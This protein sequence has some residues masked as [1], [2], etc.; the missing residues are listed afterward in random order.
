[1]EEG[2]IATQ[3][4]IFEWKGKRQK[5]QVSKWPPT[6]PN[7]KLNSG[8]SSASTPTRDSAPTCPDCGRRHRGTCYRVTG[9]C[10]KIVLKGID[11]MGIEPLLVGSTLI[12]STKLVAKTT[13]NKDTARQGTVFALVPGDVQNAVA[14]VSSTFTIHGHS[15]HVLFHS[16]STH[17]FVSKIFVQ[18]LNRPVELLP[19]VLCVSSP[20]GDFMACT[21]IYFACEFLIRDTRVYANLL[22]LDMTHFDIILGMDW[23]SEYQTTIDYVTKQISFHPPGQ[24]EFTFKGHGVI[25]PPYLISAMKGC[26]LLQKG[27]QGY[28][29][30]VLEGQ[31]MNGGIDMISIVREFPDVFPEELPGELV[32][33]KIEFTIEV[34]PGTQPISKTSYRMSPVE[35]KELKVQLQDLLDKGFICSSVSPWGAPVLFVKKKDGTLR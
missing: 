29:C 10:F 9:A 11:K 27:C 24:S 21:S 22:P 4:R 7:K 32:D 31:S 20:L 18:N 28:L 15:A 1:M 23:L 34:V 16:G 33:R 8:T 19:Y 35:V 12:P 3:N 30:S 14:V 5:T 2:N 25:S 26:K 17:S 6:P 13:N